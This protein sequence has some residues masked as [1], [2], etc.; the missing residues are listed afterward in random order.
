MQERLGLE[1][2]RHDAGE[3]TSEV[4][5]IASGLH[6]IRMVFDLM[7]TEG[8][9]AQADVA[10]RLNRVRRHAGGLQDHPARGRRRRPGQLQG[11][12]GRGGQAV[13][14]LDRPA[15][16]Q[17]LPR[18]GAAVGRRRRAR[19]R[20]APGRGGGDRGDRR[21]R[22][23]PAHRAGPARAGQAGRRPGALRAGLAVLPRR[24]GRPGRDVRL[25][26][27][28]AGPA[29]GRDAD[30]GRPDRR[31]GRHHR[32]GGGACSTPTRPAPSR[33]RRRSG[34]GCRRWPTRR[35]ASCTAPTST[36]RSRSA[37]SSAASPRPAT[38]RSTT[39]GRARTSPA[40]GGCGGRCRRASPTSPPGAR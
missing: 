23:L 24:E 5:V 18:P 22:P 1:L 3:I 31:A 17:L 2:A 29:G 6:E 11:A 30:G 15:R 20:A 25:G 16:R 39:P 7:P 28:G 14:H 32:R 13:R 40:P 38:A 21:V 19:C 27:R 34:T 33:A 12:V 4:N 9:Q 26:F 37:G 35:S 10:A 36:S 8:E